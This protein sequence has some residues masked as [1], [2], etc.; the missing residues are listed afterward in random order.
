M[1][2]KIDMEQRYE[3]ALEAVLAL[4]EKDSYADRTVIKTICEI[5]LGKCNEAEECEDCD[6]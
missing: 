5:A 1:K 2:G 3:M 6:E 4:I